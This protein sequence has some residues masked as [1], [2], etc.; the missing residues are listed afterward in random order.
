MSEFKKR[1]SFAYIS[2]LPT[3]VEIFPFSTS[4]YIIAIYRENHFKKKKRAPILNVNE[5]DIGN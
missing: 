5:N 1:Y 4:V 3:G 2:A